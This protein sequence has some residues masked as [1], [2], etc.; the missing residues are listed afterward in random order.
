MNKTT[1]EYLANKPLMYDFANETKDDFLKKY[2]HVTKKE[3]NAIKKIIDELIS[4]NV[5]EKCLEERPIFENRGDYNFDR[6]KEML[7]NGY[8]EDN[9]N[10]QGE[11][12][13]TEEE[14]YN[15]ID[16]TEELLYNVFENEMSEF[17]G[18]ETFILRG[19]VETWQGHF[20]AGFIFDSY[21]QFSRVFYDEAYNRIYDVG[22]EFIIQIAHHDGIN[23]FKIRKLN[24]KGYEYYQDHYFDDDK[25]LHDTLVDDRYSSLPNFAHKM[26]GVKEKTY[27]YSGLESYLE[28]MEESLI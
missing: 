5:I 21:E 17:I 8:N 12:E 9:P 2:N 22:G 26:Y 16:K 7:I 13:P 28:E 6:V 25:V 11:W 24:K 20:S 27:Q 14:I 18:D 10:S 3:Y 4:K 23:Y 1:R 15:E 19:T